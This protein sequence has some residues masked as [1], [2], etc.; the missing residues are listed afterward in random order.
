[1][2]IYAIL[3]RTITSPLRERERA[4]RETFGITLCENL[5]F[6]PSHELRRNTERDIESNI[7]ADGKTSSQTDR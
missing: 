4:K 3:F 1:M 7:Q 2:L 6:M 5:I